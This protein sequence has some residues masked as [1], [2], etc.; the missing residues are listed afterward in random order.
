MASLSTLISGRVRAGRLE[1]PTGAVQ[2]AVSGWPDRDVILSIRPARPGRSLRQLRYYHGVVLPLMA[3]ATGQDEDSIHDDMCDRF[4]T[5]RHV[6][7]AN[8]HTGEVEER[9]VARRTT[10]LSVQEFFDFTERVRVFAIEFL[11]LIVP[12]PTR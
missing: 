7:Y 10:G 6:H 11:G 4:L 12:D 1:V 3:E 5:K 8:P 2:A 9:D